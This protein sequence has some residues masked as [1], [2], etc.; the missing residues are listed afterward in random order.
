MARFNPR[1]SA[2]SF[3]DLCAAMLK[4]PKSGRPA[5]KLEP[6]GDRWRYGPG[7]ELACIAY[8]DHWSALAASLSCDTAVASAAD[9]SVA[10]APER[11]LAS[12][13]GGLNSLS[14]RSSPRSLACLLVWAGVLGH[15]IATPR[16]C[17]VRACAMQ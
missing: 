4:L 13:A 5:V 9:S 15:W 14:F 10:S 3:D 8:G 17:D 1:Y 2:R 6:T 7:A 11:M 16:R 12:A